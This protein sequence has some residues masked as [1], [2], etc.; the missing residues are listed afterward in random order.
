[1]IVRIDKKY[2]E[3]KD[4][5]SSRKSICN[6]CYFQDRVCPI[7]KDR[8]CLPNKYYVYIPAIELLL[9]ELNLP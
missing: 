3:L 5:I 1:M 2:F 9:K 4:V 7:V 8:T 6:Q